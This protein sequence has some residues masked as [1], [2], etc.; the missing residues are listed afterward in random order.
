MIAKK[1]IVVFALSGALA[2]VI[3]E[4]PW[5]SSGAAAN[6]TPR[7][8]AAGSVQTIDAK[9]EPAAA[10]KALNDFCE[11]ISNCKFVGTAPIVVAY[12][13]PRVL[14]DAL[15]NCGQADAEDEVA[16]SDERSES[17]SIDEELSTKVKLGFIGLA[18]SAVEAEVDSKQLDEVATTLQQTNSVVV[19]PGTV[20][21]TETRV[22]TA[23]LTGDTDITSGVNLIKVTN[24]ELTYPGY[25]NA[26]I[27]KLDWTDVHK[28]MTDQERHEHCAG[29]PPLYP[30]GP[31]PV[32]G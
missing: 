29:L 15:Y 2:A 25:G 3:A 5:Q 11:T 10:G 24:I 12:D 31:P 6:V 28:A 14:G 19:A 9:T 30:V 1:V 20:G 32:T 4:A 27:N 22:P 18:H 26:A 21:Y 7:V 16:I 13:A 23:Y 17:T 8:R